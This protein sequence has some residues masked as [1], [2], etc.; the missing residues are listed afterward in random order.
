ME[1]IRLMYDHIS[2]FILSFLSNYSCMEF[3]FF[4]Q[5]TSEYNPAFIE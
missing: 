5:A 2:T 4:V 1:T 3:T